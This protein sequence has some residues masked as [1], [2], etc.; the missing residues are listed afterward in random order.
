[1]SDRQT[2]PL[3]PGQIVTTE[4]T[5]RFIDIEGGCWVIETAAGR[6]YEP[7]NLSSGLHTDGLKV[8][9]VMSDA[10]AGASIC[11]V[12]PLVTLDSIVPR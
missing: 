5:V 11:Q 6:H 9:V 4:A 3:M 8:N 1:M 7:V 12:G 2:A 10:S